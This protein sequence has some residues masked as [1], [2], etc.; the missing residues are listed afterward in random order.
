MRIALNLKGISYS[1]ISHHLRRNEQRATDYLRLNPQGLV[2]TLEMDGHLL[3]QSLAIIEYLEERLPDPPLLPRDPAARAR[4]W[5]A[6]GFAAMEAMLA[7]SSA[8]KRFAPAKHR[9]SRT[10]V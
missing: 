4:V 8:T 3:Y 7:G 10:S 9:P 2:P 1:S 5:I 6:E